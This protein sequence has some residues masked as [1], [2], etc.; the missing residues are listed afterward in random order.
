MQK[1]NKRLIIISIFITILVFF[2][3]VGTAYAYFIA[4]ITGNT[5]T[6]PTVSGTTAILSLTLKNGNSISAEN[7]FPGWTKTLNFDVENTGNMTTKYNVNFEDIT[8]SLIGKSNLT[9]SLSCTSSKKSTCNGKT[10]V[11]P[12]TS[13]L[14]NIVTN[15]IEVGEVQ[16]YT[17]TVTFANSGDQSNDIGK[18]FYAKVTIASE[19]N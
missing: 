7:I 1:N 19:K 15:N 6:S 8:N 12:D 14:Q 13:S 11:F 4:N 16:T 3:I 18:S 9:Y 5:Q 2:A 17:V 10:G